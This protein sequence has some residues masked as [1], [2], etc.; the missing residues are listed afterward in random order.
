LKTG[1]QSND[2]EINS[3]NT[4]QVLMLKCYTLK[5]MTTLTDSAPSTD[6]YS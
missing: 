1:P 2:D 3:T 6:K 4:S 5:R